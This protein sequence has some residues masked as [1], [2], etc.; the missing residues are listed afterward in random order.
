MLFERAYCQV[1]LCS[2]SRT[3]LLTGRR[4]DTNHVW[5]IDPMEYWRR[6]TNAT[7]I[8][9]YFKEHGYISIGMGKVFH[10]GPANGNDDAKY[11]WSPE[12]LPYYHSP[13]NKAYG[14]ENRTSRKQ[15]PST[16]QTCCSNI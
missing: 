7:T 14:P 12:G 16:Q 3:S 15:S 10:P 8:P 4:P 2:P 6:F 9:Q 5:L 1:A 11:S 13:L